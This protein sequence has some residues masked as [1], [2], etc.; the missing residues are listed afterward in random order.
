[1]FRIL[2]SDAATVKGPITLGK[3]KTRTEARKEMKAIQDRYI[4]FHGCLASKVTKDKLTTVEIKNRS[5]VQTRTK[6][7]IDKMHGPR[8]RDKRRKMAKV[9]ATA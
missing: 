4:N 8:E 3:F 9:D 7:W 2:H 1:M 5:R 6:T